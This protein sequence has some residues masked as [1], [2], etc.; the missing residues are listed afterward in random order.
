MYEHVVSIVL[1]L[2]LVLIFFFQ[3]FTL[4]K[5]NEGNYSSDDNM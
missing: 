3:T 1:S 4:A 2:L 5:E